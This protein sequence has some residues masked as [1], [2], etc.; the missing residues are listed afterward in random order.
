LHHDTLQAHEVMV[1]ADERAIH[2]LPQVGAAW[3]LHGTQ[4]EIM[5][6]GTNEKH[7]L[8]GALQLATGQLLYGLGPRKNNGVFRDLLTLL[9]TAY[10]A[11]EVTRISVVVDNYR[12]PKATAV[13]QWLAHHPRFAVL[14][15]PTYC[16]RAHPIERVCGDGHDKCPWNHKRKR[17]RDLGKDVEQHVQ[18][19]GSW[20]YN[21]S[22]LY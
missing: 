9:D 22:R 8:A 21:L 17:L 13:T 1:L 15:L 2:L 3:M 10:P 20:R 14:G 11:P 5:T 6:P 19:H 4:E 16:P 12:I 7:Y 18:E